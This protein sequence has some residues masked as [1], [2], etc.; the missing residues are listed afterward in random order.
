MR[1]TARRTSSS[2]AAAVGTDDVVVV[3]ATVD[4]AVDGAAG[5]VVVASDLSSG[6]V[7]TLSVAVPPHAA[8]RSAN[9]NDTR[10]DGTRFMAAPFHE[11]GSNSLSGSRRPRPITRAFRPELT[12]VTRGV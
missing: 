8:T 5:A 10:I 2:E 6:D 11:R 1:T 12:I 4:G 7:T 3:S 9:V